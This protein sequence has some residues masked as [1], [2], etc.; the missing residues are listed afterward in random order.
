[1]STRS[2]FV[3][4]FLAALLAMGV[5]PPTDPDLGWHLQTGRYILAHGL[6]R[7]DPF[8]FTATTH[9][10]TTHEW[11]SQVAMALV[12][13]AGGL[14][15]LSLFFAGVIA[16][17]FA[18]VYAAS[19]G[20]PYLAAFITLLA[21]VASAM[22][23]GARPQLFNLL[24][25]A[26]C[27]LVLERVKDGRW[28]ARALWGLPP[29]L[30]VWANLHGG[31]LAGVAL[32]LAY[33][34]GEGAQY[35]LPWRDARRL[36]PPAL[37]TLAAVAPAGLLAA[38]L[39]P[40]GPG[41]WVYPFFTL[42]SPVMQTFI[43]EWH[44]PDFQ[45]A[46]FWPFALLLG[47]GAICWALA[48]RRPT[49][50]EALLFFGLGGAG[51]V[52]ARHIP[53]FAV[54]AAPLIGRPLTEAVAAVPRLAAG[55]LAPP[56][57]TAPR[58]RIVNAALLALALAAAG[59]YVSAELG[60]FDAALAGR[61]PV[62]AVDYLERSGL[63]GQHGF[64]S[65]N[66]GGY[67]VWR[68][69]PVFV[70]GRADVYGDE[71]LRLYLRAYLASPRWREAFAAFPVEYVLMEPDSPLVAVLLASGEWHSAYSD[72]VAVVLTPGRAP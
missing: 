9:A 69:L 63:A 23:W 27:V 32:L 68:G 61:Y 55:L 52:S 26:A 65:Y 33:L 3:A 50:T 72:A 16:L 19:P 62:A 29:L 18:A 17:T 41:L 46:M 37:R 31:F 71:F 70:D 44:S 13:Q 15:G 53:L 7:T 1:M 30:A 22:V 45:Q 25:L 6:P 58:L 35:V 43:Q 42:G 66:W 39:N 49:A 40:S 38:A 60:K 21:A 64:N 24:G 10:W 4:L 14:P 56:P 34:A 12:E 11:L 67:L 2:L 47:G 57:P 51:L 48:A 28:P 59:A 20:R 8:S 36:P 5:R 54:V